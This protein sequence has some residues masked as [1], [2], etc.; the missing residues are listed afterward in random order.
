MARIAEVTYVTGVAKLLLASRLRLFE[1][2][3]VA[4]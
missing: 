4:L 3:H 1:P 2:L